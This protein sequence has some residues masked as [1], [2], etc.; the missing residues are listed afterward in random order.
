[1]SEK[2][3]NRVHGVADIKTFNFVDG[4]IDIFG[5]LEAEICKFEVFLV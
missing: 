2:L 5:P 4:Y 3:P 1:M